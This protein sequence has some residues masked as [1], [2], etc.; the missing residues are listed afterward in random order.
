MMANKLGLNLARHSYLNR[1]ALIAGYWLLIIV[2]AVFLLFQGWRIYSLQKNHT[3]LGQ[4]LATLDKELSQV[5]GLS[6][7]EVSAEDI[8]RQK[9]EIQADND[10]LRR[11]S[12]SW[13]RQLD[14]LE[15]LMVDGVTI[16]AIQ[17]NYKDGVLR[18][19]ATAEG[20]EQMRSFIDTLLHSGEFSDVFLM[21]QSRTPYIDSRK[22]KHEAINFNLL[23]KGAF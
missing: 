9:E 7:K 23:L 16:R 6:Q 1:R 5:G 8:A 19:S 2:L 20:V 17:P 4:Q 3:E 10:I 18:V 12:F 15:R 14:R 21:D 13:T 22:Q 11:E